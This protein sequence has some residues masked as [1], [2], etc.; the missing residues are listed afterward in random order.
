MGRR[1]DPLQLDALRQLER[2]LTMRAGAQSCDE[3]RRQWLAAPVGDRPSRATSRGSLPA[4]ADVR[5]ARHRSDGRRQRRDA[6]GH[7]REMQRRRA[8]CEVSVDYDC[9]QHAPGAVNFADMTGRLTN[10]MR[11]SGI[12][13][14]V[15]EHALTQWNHRCGSAPRAT[16]CIPRSA[17]A[18]RSPSRPSPRTRLCAATSCSAVMADAC[19]RT[20]S[21]A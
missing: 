7:A 19:S 2:G 17:T 18:K 20:A 8:R 14:A 9:S 13:S 3:R 5:N 15:I 4:A 12:F 10:P 16:A 21:S 6:P 1:D 11:H